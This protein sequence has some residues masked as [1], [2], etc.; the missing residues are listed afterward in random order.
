MQ[1]SPRSPL[2]FTPDPVLSQLL[3][4]QHGAPVLIALHD[5]ADRL[6]YA[7]PAF[8]SAYGL[9]ADESLTWAEIMRRCHAN[10]TGA[11]IETDDIEA[12]IASASTRRGKQP[13]RAFEVDLRDGRWL[14]IS[15]TVRP[16]GWLLLVAMDIT[17]LRSGERSL[18][19]QRD[20]ALRAAQ[21]DALTGISNRAHILQQLDEHLAVLRARGQC[22][23]LVLLDLD[24][25]KAVND[26]FGHAAG[27]AV[28]HDFAGT[29]QRGLRRG[30]GFGRLGGEEF[31]L[32]LPG[33][34]APVVQA[35][36]E[37]L[38]QQVSLRRPL[39]EAPDFGYSCSAGMYMLRPQDDTRTACI[40]ADRAMYAAKA[41][42]R[43]RA[44]WAD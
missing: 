25:F 36:V 19:Q 33:A 17:P 1:T 41:I 10:G 20:R 42:G 15:E 3:A 14:W 21:T 16:D 32:L 13:F 22:C 5:D 6:C 26:R 4:M 18:R 37:R 31:M 27:D 28:L 9:G 40:H 35:V 7:N 39:A 8:R 38:L 23:G 12:W 29:V 2:P 24:N 43:D 44:V 30:D 34:P 11:L